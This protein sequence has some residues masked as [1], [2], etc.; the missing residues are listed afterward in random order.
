MTAYTSGNSALKIKR[1]HDGGLFQLFISFDL[2]ANDKQKARMIV[3][4]ERLAA[5]SSNPFKDMDERF[6]I[7]KDIFNLR[8]E[9]DSTVTHDQLMFNDYN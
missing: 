3:L 5:L 1:G 7:A 2:V 9:T 4:R 6:K 8:R